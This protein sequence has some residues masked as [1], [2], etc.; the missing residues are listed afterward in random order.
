[1]DVLAGM[2][3]GAGL[4][5]RAWPGRGGS[6]AGGMAVAGDGGRDGGDTRMAVAVTSVRRGSSRYRVD[7]PARARLA[8]GSGGGGRTWR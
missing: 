6:G 4:P 1:M 7:G 3:A 8:E 5:S 2:V